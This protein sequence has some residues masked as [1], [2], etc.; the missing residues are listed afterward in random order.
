M[1]L[2][3]SHM[4]S[5]VMIVIHAELF[6]KAFPLEGS[7]LELPTQ[8]FQKVIVWVSI[9]NIKKKKKKKKKNMVPHFVGALFKLSRRS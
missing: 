2:F 1:Q 7:E 3:Q 9:K 5:K 8:L 4:L 6:R